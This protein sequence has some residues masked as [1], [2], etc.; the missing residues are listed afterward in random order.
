MTK[1]TR[2]NEQLPPLHTADLHLVPHIV[3]VSHMASVRKTAGASSTPSASTI[4]IVGASS[5]PSA[6]TI[7]GVGAS[8]TASADGS[9]LQLPS[10]AQAHWSRAPAS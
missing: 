2:D 3:G 1:R 10:M 7:T 9:L 8:D 6:S 5:T 4:M